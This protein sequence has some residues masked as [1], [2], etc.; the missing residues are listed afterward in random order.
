MGRGGG[1]KYILWILLFDL[2]VGSLAFSQDGAT[3]LRCEEVLKVH[4]LPMTSSQ[5]RG[6]DLREDISRAHER[7]LKSQ[8][9]NAWASNFVYGRAREIDVKDTSG[10]HVISLGSGPDIFL[11]LYLF[12]EARYFHLV[13]LI[14]GWGQGPESVVEEIEARL[15]SLAG[16]GEVKRLDHFSDEEIFDGGKLKLPLQGPLIWR[17]RWVSLKQGPQE[18]IF[19]LHQIDFNNSDQ[20]KAVRDYTTH[21]AYQGPL[22]GIVV[23]GIS[24]S[25]KTRRLLLEHLQQGGAMFTEMLYTNKEGQS[26]SPEDS[27]IL[28]SLSADYDV[29]DLG[30]S[31]LEHFF[32]PHTFVIKRKKIE[33]PPF[34]EGDWGHELVAFLLDPKI[35]SLQKNSLLVEKTMELQK[36]YGRS[37]AESV[38]RKVQ[39][40]VRTLRQKKGMPWMS[41]VPVMKQ[42]SDSNLKLFAPAFMAPLKALKGDLQTLDLSPN[43]QLA[44]AGTLAEPRIRFYSAQTGEL[45]YAPHWNAD[46]EGYVNQ[47]KFSSSGQKV[48]SASRD[49]TARVWDSKSA[50]EIQILHPFLGKPVVAA[51]FS[52]DEKFVV[53]LSDQNQMSVWDWKRRVLIHKFSTPKRQCS[54]ELCKVQ[55]FPDGF[56]ILL[57]QVGQRPEIWDLRHPQKTILLSPTHHRPSF[58]FGRVEMSPDGSKIAGFSQTGDFLVW[59]PMTGALAQE[60][61]SL[62]INNQILPVN[63]TFSPDSRYLLMFYFD[64]YVSLG[65]VGAEN[66]GVLFRVNNSE[67]GWVEGGRISQNGKW[68]VLFLSNGIAEIWSLW[69]QSTEY[70]LLVH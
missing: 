11:P 12:P 61:V 42:A 9:K 6:K 59:D 39:K 14:S 25:E 37:V 17:V 63:L 64:G 68:A 15:Q 22:G 4:L 16:G 23:T 55:F 31:G 70:D 65:K 69:D 50:R 34:S 18:Q 60:P 45:L 20:L 58:K 40:K 36:K 66:S 26:S 3:S 24:A 41:K 46:H 8:R 2:S 62:T 54:P 47:V 51:D 43:G 44:V 52:F 35:N 53:L 10:T 21:K 56:R 29:T 32:T 49:G 28:R 33:I 48:I 19:F 13:D 57:S 67:A 27:E 38:L 5:Q 30:L 1:F 7:D